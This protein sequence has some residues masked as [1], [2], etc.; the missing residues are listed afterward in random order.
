[1]SAGPNEL[2]LRKVLQASATALANASR[3]WDSGRAALKSVTAEL[4]KGI[5]GMDEEM[6]A[7]TRQ[8]ALA[9]FQRMRDRVTQHELSL[10]LGRD[11]LEIAAGAIDRATHVATTGLPPVHTTPRKQSS[12]DPASDAVE[13]A[14]AVRAFDQSVSSREEAAAEALRRL[15]A[16]LDVS[17]TKMREARG[18]PPEDL[19]PP[20]AGSGAG[21]TSKSPAG[22]TGHRAG[23]GPAGGSAPLPRC[24]ACST[25]S[26]HWSM[27]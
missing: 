25:R 7:N 26:R 5:A 10:K 1:V 8:A 14:R 19:Q 24:S 27:P 20:K 13:F 11:A 16:S 15:D 4:D 9:S 18:V 23:S 6:G 3:D 21:S 12:A 17:I 2:E 22:F